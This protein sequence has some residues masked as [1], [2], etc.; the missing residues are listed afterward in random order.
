[1]LPLAI[2]DAISNNA[3][4]SQV[5][6]DEFI[7]N[8]N[9][10]A[11]SNPNGITHGVTI[12]KKKDDISDSDK[13]PTEIQLTD[14]SSLEL[15]RQGK[16]I[17]KII[18]KDER[19]SVAEA[20]IYIDNMIAILPID[21]TETLVKNVKTSFADSISE[22]SPAGIQGMVLIFQSAPNLS[23]IHILLTPSC[24]SVFISI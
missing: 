22:K 18:Y 17:F 8:W 20:N 21:S 9:Q 5:S 6:V 11:L 14:S 1:M 24:T 23:L 19:F 16:D 10:E 15:S 2:N 4:Y 12:D 7:A 3:S 13:F